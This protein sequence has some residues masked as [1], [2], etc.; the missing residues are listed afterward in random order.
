MVHKPVMLSEVIQYLDPKPGNQVIDATLD[1]GGHAMAIAGQMVPNGKVLGIELD[2][3]LLKQFELENLKVSKFKDNFILVNDSYVNIKNIV[4]EHNFRPNG[5]LFD[6]GLSSWHYEK[7][8]RGFSFKKDESLDMRFDSRS[9]LT[10]A[11]IVNMWSENEIEQI[12]KE[13]GEEQF[14]KQIARSIISA[15]KQ[16]PIVSTNDLVEVISS[17]VPG[18]YK[19]RK[20]HFATKTFQAL[21]VAVNDE[22]NNVKKGIYNAIDVLVSGGRL[23]VISFQGLEDKTVKE[24]FREKAKEGVVKFVVKGTVKP[25]WEEVRSNP[26]AR[27]AKMKIIEKI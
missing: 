21:R 16:K 26:R 18:W 4:R 14:S 19:N 7:S 24:I 23:V 25:T 1:G 11:E 9:G 12:L 5:I 10:G 20:I 15:R 3:E 22:L 17:S 8:G 27:S 6:L 13:Y 2:G